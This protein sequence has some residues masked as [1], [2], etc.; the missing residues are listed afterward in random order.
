MDI[1]D[2]LRSEGYKVTPQRLAIYDT[3]HGSHDHPTAEM[4]YR[5]L[6]DDYPAMSLATVYKTMEIFE[7]IGLVR[8]LDTGD[9]SKR[10]D[11]E[12]HDHPHIRCTMCNRVDDMHGVS[13]ESIVASVSDHTDYRVT[14]HQ[15]SFEG[16]CPDCARKKMN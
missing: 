14:G 7:K 12:V 6:R 9:D 13:T 15:L 2:K 11:W 4:I 16:I 5:G 3:V 8:I 1:A 10:Y